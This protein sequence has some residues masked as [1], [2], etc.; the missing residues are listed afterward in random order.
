MKTL[1]KFLKFFCNRGIWLRSKKVELLA[2]IHDHVIGKS[3]RGF[4]LLMLGW[5]DGFSF[6]P[7]AFNMLSSAKQEKRFKEINPEIDRSTNGY[8]ARTA[9]I[10]QKPDAAITL[11]PV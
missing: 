1:V 9:A 10:I 3:V 4:N 11:Y 5:T 2:F 7:V 8:K 6:I